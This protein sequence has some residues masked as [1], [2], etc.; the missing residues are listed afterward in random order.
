MRRLINNYPDT[1]ESVQKP[2]NSGFEDKLIR[3]CPVSGVGRTAVS[4]GN[5]DGL[6]LGHMTLVT[7]LTRRASELGLPAVIYTFHEHPQ[8]VL[9]GENGVKLLIDRQKKLELLSA[10]GVD[11]VYFEHFDREFAAMAPEDFIKRILVD[12]FGA[13]L[14]AVGSNY[15]FGRRGSGDVGTLR[16]Y[17]DK[18]GFLVEEVKPLMVCDHGGITAGR[19]I[20][21]SSYIRELLAACRVDTAG[22]ALGRL[23]S[24]RGTAAPDNKPLLCADAAPGITALPMDTDTRTVRLITM[25]TDTRTTRLVT[26]DTDTRITRLVTMDAGTRKAR[27]IIVNTD[28]RMASPGPGVYVTS[29]RVG[30]GMYRGYTRIVDD[31]DDARAINYVFDFKDNLHEAEIEIFFYHTTSSKVH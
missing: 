19:R 11:G 3:D 21:S 27:P 7:A 31:A 8:N 29:T 6:H 2:R 12:G 24:M 18:Y 22:R 23:F 14:V 17:G 16:K 13:R 28:E 26:M 9:D 15:R 1:A 5:F 4:L 25:D 30:G 10:T 20:I